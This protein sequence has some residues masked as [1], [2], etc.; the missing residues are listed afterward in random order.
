MTDPE[1]NP[2]APSP[3]DEAA[4]RKASDLSQQWG[5]RL[6][7]FHLPC[8][9]CKGAL[10]F[11]GVT[12]EQFYEFSEG[13]PGAVEPLALYPLIFICDHCGYTAEFDS[14]LFNP[15]YLARLSGAEPRAAEALD[16][17]RF[18]ALVALR[19]DEHNETLLDLATALVGNRGGVVIVLN[20][21]RSE[22]LA[23]ECEAR[24]HRYTPAVGN[25]APVRVV[26][27]GNRK[28]EK[29]LPE[30]MAREQCD[31]LLLEARGWPRTEE[32]DLAAGLNAVLARPGG[33]VAL[34]Y[35]HGLA[36]VNRILFATAGGPSARAAAPFALQLAR[37]FAAD[38]HL[39]Y[40]A[41]SQ[42][43]QS[44]E[45]GQQHLIDTL[46]GLEIA[47]ADQIQRRVVFGPDPVQII[48]NEAAGYDL[49]ITG[50]SPIGRRGPKKL[51]SRSD[52]ITRNA[53]NTALNVLAKDTRQKSW[54][55]RLLG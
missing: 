29:L 26:R 30:I 55:S 7:K 37:A 38:L 6:D 25:P 40:V 39:L 8:P 9:L 49:L 11:H 27:R 52:K 22:A 41:T 17:R 3:S 48:L 45:V 43:D 47:G 14:E 28:L 24:L 23:D 33:D 4:E 54:L 44:E 5:A 16:I 20:A 10:A 18:R 2:P 34:V 1:V 19:G 35:D 46:A 13:E 31:W 32:P 53:P 42:D 51:E 36:R 15:A 50:G 12:P 21:A